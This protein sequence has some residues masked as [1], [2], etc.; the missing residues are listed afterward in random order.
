MDLYNEHNEVVKFSYFEKIFHETLPRN[1]VFEDI[2]EHSF[3]FNREDGFVIGLSFLDFEMDAY[4]SVYKKNRSIISLSYRDA[5]YIKIIDDKHTI[6]EIISTRC[7]YNH[8]ASKTILTLTDSPIVQFND[9][10][11]NEKRTMDVVPTDLM[12]LFDD[13]DEIKHNESSNKVYRFLCVRFSETAELTLFPG[14]GK[15]SLIIKSGETLLCSLNL[16]NCDRIVANLKEKKMYF[17]SGFEELEELSYIE[18]SLNLNEYLYL[19][20]QP[21]SKPWLRGL[22]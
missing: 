15:L 20:I 11:E 2:Y 9:D 8:A 18:G 7:E 4:I 5:D 14:T 19:L 6:F 12:L 22:G 21:N 10:P 1:E 3:L 13:F 17:T 16:V